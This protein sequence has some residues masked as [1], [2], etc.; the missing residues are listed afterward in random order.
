M[1]NPQEVRKQWKLRVLK[2]VKETKEG[3]ESDEAM[4]KDIEWNLDS[5]EEQM[6]QR[7]ALLT[8]EN[9]SKAFELKKIK[10]E[11]LN[12]EKDKRIAKIQLTQS[13]SRFQEQLRVKTHNLEV[14]KRQQKKGVKSEIRKTE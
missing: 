5:F 13:L 7:K 2:R 3:I 12:F 6:E 8:A 1:G 10:Q 14:Y 9:L 11:L 4:I